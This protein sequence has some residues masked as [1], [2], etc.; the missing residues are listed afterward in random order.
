ML[1]ARCAGQSYCKGR[2]K[3]L[4]CI[5]D[6]SSEPTAL[7]QPLRRLKTRFSG[8]M[9][10]LRIFSRKTFRIVRRNQMLPGLC[11]ADSVLLK[12]SARAPQHV[13]FLA[14]RHAGVGR[15]AAALEAASVLA[16]H[17]LRDI[18]TVGLHWQTDYLY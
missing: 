16:S 14:A 17:G 7:L 4:S 18:D 5:F 2:L 11:S 12:K 10:Q 9:R 13:A 15:R 8:I 3:G 6:L 1:S